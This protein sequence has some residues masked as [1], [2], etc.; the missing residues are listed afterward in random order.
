[1]G[2]A[3]ITIPM[4]FKAR[5]ILVWLA[6]FLYMKDR[7]EGAF[8][9]GREGAKM[10]NHYLKSTLKSSNT[11]IAIKWFSSSICSAL[12]LLKESVSKHAKRGVF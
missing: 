2:S 7:T 3:S 1:M 4:I 12:M 9:I 11:G 6:S 8:L 5:N 10:C